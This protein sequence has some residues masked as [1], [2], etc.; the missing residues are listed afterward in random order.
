MYVVL[1]FFFTYIVGLAAYIVLN[2]LQEALGTEIGGLNDSVMRFGP[3]LAA[4]LI[5]LLIDGKAGVAGL[6]WRLV[7]RPGPAWLLLS[8]LLLPP[9]ILSLTFVFRGYGGTAPDG[10]Y[11]AML[12]V[13]A[14]K[15]ATIAIVGA[16]LG[17]E[18][19]WRG[20]M[21]P[22]LA[23]RRGALL[24]TFWVALA[25]LLWHVPAFLLADK[26]EADPFLPFVAIMLPLSAVLTWVYYRSGEGLLAPVLLH[27]S[28]NASFYTLVE[29]YPDLEAAPAF[30]P[31]FDWTVAGLWWLAAIGLVIVAGP[32]LGQRF[33]ARR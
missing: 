31:G 9:L 1:A 22:Q 5:L 25:W 17:E 26:G 16:G 32:H 21:L 3:S 14:V 33:G 19:G 8:A 13:F 11:A 18:L 6:L 2:N 28:L 30:Q 15:F 20:F 10:G 23:R 4:L 12:T 7:R 24:A 27:A 29:A